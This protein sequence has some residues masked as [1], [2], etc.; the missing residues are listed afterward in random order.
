MP[1]RVDAMSALWA[2][3]P[4][5]AACRMTAS[6]AGDLYLRRFHTI[7]ELSRTSA[8]G[9]RSR[10]C[11]TNWSSRVSRPSH[12]LSVIDFCSALNFSLLFSR[13]SSSGL[14]IV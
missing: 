7:A 5:R 4:R 1:G 14:N 13:P 6:S 10:S 12:G 8:C 3:T 11:L 9:N 2:W